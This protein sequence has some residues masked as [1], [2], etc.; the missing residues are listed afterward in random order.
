MKKPRAHAFTPNPLLKVQLPAGRSRFAMLMLACGFTALMVRAVW[1]QVW[2]NEFLKQE[3]EKRYMRTLELPAARGRITDR[4][5]AILATSLPARAVF[6]NPTAT[7]LDAEQVSALA[8]LLAMPE[9]DLARRLAAE[10]KTFVYLKRQVDAATAEKIAALKLSGV[11]QLPEYKRH[12]PDGA[13]IAHVVGFTNVEDVGQE[14]I[15]LTHQKDLAGQP[16]T[17]RV[18]QDRMG[19]VVEE[20]AAL[21]E[22]QDGTDLQLSIDARLQYHAFDAVRDAVAQHRALAGAAVIIDVRTGEVLA[23]ANLP[24]YDPNERGA[25]S[26]AQLRNRVMTDT[27]EP[28]STFKPFAISA[29]L[30]AGIVKPSSMINC[31]GKLTIGS[32]SIGDAHGH[33][34]LSVEEVLQKSSNVGTAKIAL[35]LPAQRMWELYSALGFGQAPDV[36]FPGAVAGRVRPWKTWKPIEQATM[37]YGHGISVSLLQLARAYS[38]F[39][40][41]GELVTLSFLKTDQPAAL[42]QIIRPE[43]ARAVRHMLELAAGPGGTAPKAQIAGF[44]VAGKTGTAHKQDGGRYVNRYVSSFVGFAPASNPRV[45][46]AVM[47]DEPSNGAHY[48]GTVAAPIFARIASDTMRTLQILP[49][50]P[51]RVQAPAGPGAPASS[52]RA[53]VAPAPGAQASPARLQGPTKGQA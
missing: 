20:V 1:L 41:D 16:G 2:S 53:G 31:A 11:H 27:F 24:T 3:G 47:L 22:P 17:R 45:V 30:E 40:R 25:L 35:Q 28:G 23:L 26:G 18:M 9:R 39:A 14:G 44:R 5:G 15:E 49:D 21:R 37:S 46:I 38:I 4:N 36:G 13:T 19:N 52:A 42:Q 10:S 32:A 33:G 12:Y 7:H 6:A 43:T 51:L 48:G 8:R 50:L 29:A 34:T